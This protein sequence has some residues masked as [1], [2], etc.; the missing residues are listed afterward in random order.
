LKQGRQ[1]QKSN[2]HERSIAAIFTKA[3]Y[4]DGDGE[5]RRTPMSGGWDKRA[6]PGDLIPLKFMASQSAQSETGMNAVLDAAFPFSIECKN[7]KDVKHFFTGLYSAESDIF[8]W[9]QQSISDAAPSGKTPVVVFKLY[10][11]ENVV[12]IQA[13][14]FNKLREYFGLFPGAV[15]GATKGGLEGM[16]VIFIMLKD[17]IEWIDWGFYKLQGKARYI[18]SIVKSDDAPDKAE[19]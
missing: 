7:W 15:Y 10:R 18:R 11:S 8:N 4:E 6:A 1:K 13:R 14:D 5:F 9:M 2:A 19:G 16:A 17:F 3:F 12:L